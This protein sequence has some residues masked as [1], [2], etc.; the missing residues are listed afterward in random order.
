[1]RRLL[2][3]NL[4]LTGML[5]GVLLTWHCAPG[6]HRRDDLARA[7]AQPRAGTTPCEQWEVLRFDT[8]LRSAP[9]GDELAAGFT[10]ELGR[11]RRLD[12]GQLMPVGW[13]PFADDADRGAY[14]WARR[15]VK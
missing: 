3:V 14:V 13:E 2:A 5:L 1:M 15:C 6:T 11:E 4:V 8:D 7:T 9:D 12:Y 10:D